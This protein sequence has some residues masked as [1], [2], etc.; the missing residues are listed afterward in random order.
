MPEILLILFGAAVLIALPIMF[1]ATYVRALGIRSL[2]QRLERLERTVAALQAGATGSDRPVAPPV[3]APESPQA[4]PAEPALAPPA[5]SEPVVLAAEIA[6]PPDQVGAWERLIGGQALGWLAVVVLLFASG[7]FLRYAFENQWIGPV[8]RVSLGVLAGTALAFAGRQYHRRGW[9]VFSQMLTAGGVVLLYLSTYGAFGF[10][11][12][13]GHREAGVALALLVVESVLLA[14][15]YEAPAIALMAVVGG[16]LTPLLMHSDRDQYRSLFLYLVMLDAG[17][18]A[19]LVWRNWRLI[20]LVGMAGTQLLFW[21][22]HWD[23]YHPE[24]LGWAIGFQT[25]VYALFLAPTLAAWRARRRSDWEDL[26]RMP[27]DAAFCFGAVYV[28]LKPEY[29][30]WLGALAVAVAA[31]YALAARWL[32]AA[33]PHDGPAQLT[34][35]AIATGFLALAFP[36]QADAPWVALGW[37]AEAAGLWWF[38]V[39]IRS[40]PL[41]AMAASLAA[42]SA[43]R[44]GLIDMPWM[45]HA[46]GWPV[47]NRY[48]LPALAAV[49]GLAGGLTASRRWLARLSREELALVVVAAIG[50]VLMV[51][52]LVSAD[53]VRYFSDL[54]QSRAGQRDWM[55]WAQT[56]VSVWWAAYATLA[57]GVGFYARQSWLRWTALGLYAVVAAK[58]FLVDMSELNELYRIAA[59]FVLALVL[60]AAAWAYQRFQPNRSADPVT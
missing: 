18:A 24:K 35:L 7:F 4:G 15:C 60:G 12:L 13:I 47:F 48:A 30:E 20:G 51:W 11:H 49:V 38:G 5:A 9:R 50:C 31:L 58:V 19:L 1:I 39:R 8:G 56:C 29:S 46:G 42:L 53:I 28:L 59:F 33:R 25:A 43:G 41:R 3:P 52:A 14:V 17:V 27:L 10:Y 21:L 2:R 6:E 57:L 45:M 26:I 37:A 32:L 44:V 55:R 23:N 40:I 54:S 34:A 22:W 36:L 16:L